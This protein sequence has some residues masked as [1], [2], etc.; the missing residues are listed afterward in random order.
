MTILQH[1]D[2]SNGRAYGSCSKGSIV[3]RGVSV[4]GDNYTSQLHVT[5]TPDTVGTTIECIYNDTDG[6]YANDT[7]SLMIP[8]TGLS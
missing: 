2:F 1:D 3:A 8:T 7:L 4:E 6:S 5:V